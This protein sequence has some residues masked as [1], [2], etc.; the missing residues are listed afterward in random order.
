MKEFRYRVARVALL[1]LVLGAPSLQAGRL[2]A[3]SRSG[4]DAHA[5]SGSGLVEAKDVRAAT[6]TI[7]GEVYGVTPTTRIFD[8]RGERIVLDKLPVARVFR[9][10]PKVDVEALVSFE[11]TETSRGWVLESVQVQAAPPR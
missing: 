5:A 4:P 8:A 2:G 1:A 7:G 6:V 9:D 11:A 10:E 3:P